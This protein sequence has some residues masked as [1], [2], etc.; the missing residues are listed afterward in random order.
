MIC[1][2]NN[3]ANPI[4]VRRTHAVWKA[5]EEGPPTDNIFGHSV[6]HSY[7]ERRRQ[8]IA[9][10]WPALEERIL[11]RLVWGTFGLHRESIIQR[12]EEM[13]ATGIIPESPFPLNRVPIDPDK[14]DCIENLIHP[15]ALR[16][17]L[18]NL[19]FSVKVYAHFGGSKG[20]LY[21]AA[22]RILRAFSPVTLGR[23]RAFKIVAAKKQSSEG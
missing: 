20:P 3:A 10:R 15:H 17:E 13:L 16:D 8:I 14:G 12:A 6:K 23:A 1:D 18:R 9:E 19:G 21:A 7:R 5:F 4:I 22:N 2:A 11:E